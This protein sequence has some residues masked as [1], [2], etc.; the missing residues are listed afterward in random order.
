MKKVNIVFCCKTPIEF[1]EYGVVG[2][3]SVLGIEGRVFKS[4]YSDSFNKLS[5]IYFSNFVL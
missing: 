1:S 5:S 4:H 2:S 3:V